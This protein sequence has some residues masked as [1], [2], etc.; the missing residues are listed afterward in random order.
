[1][2]L[3][4]LLYVSKEA[5]IAKEHQ[6]GLETHIYFM[7]VRSYGKDF[8]RS[9]YERAEKEWG[10]LQEEQGPEDRTG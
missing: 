2:L 7:D 8:E 1:M 6:P 3:L 4:R 9:T 10:R 5:V